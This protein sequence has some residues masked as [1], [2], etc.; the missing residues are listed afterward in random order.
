ME[1]DDL[2]WLLTWFNSQ[3][4]GDWE[5]CYGMRITTINNPGWHIRF[6][7]NETELED[8]QFQRIDVERSKEDWLNCYVE[9]GMF[10]GFCGP[11]NLHEILQIFHDWSKN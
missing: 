9:N 11:S 4:D 7:L 3:C 6:C 8:Q 5:H 2:S 1:N 10:E